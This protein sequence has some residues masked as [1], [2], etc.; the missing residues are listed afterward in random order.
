MLNLFKLS[1]PPADKHNR[2][3]L[4]QFRCLKS[5]GA[6]LNPSRRSVDAQ[7]NGVNKA[8]DQQNDRPSQPN[9][10][11]LL[12][13]MIVNQGTSN[14]ADKTDSEPKGLFLQKSKLIPVTIRSKCTGTE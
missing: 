9:H 5:K 8:E 14:C 10:P 7:T 4:C 12:P 6:N 11:G 1:E 13:P 2:T 3:Q